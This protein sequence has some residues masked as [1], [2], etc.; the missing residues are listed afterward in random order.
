MRR[1][2][3]FSAEKLVGD[4]L[5]RVLD[6]AQRVLPKGDR[7]L[8]VGR[9]RA[10]ILKKVGPLATADPAKVMDQ[11]A[12]I[13]DPK[14]IVKQELE[15]L[16]TAHRGGPP[17]PVV[18]WR[19]TKDEWTPGKEDTEPIP[20]QSAAPPR[21]AEPSPGGPSLAGPSSGGRSPAGSRAG[22]PPPAGSRAGG[23][24]PA[25]SRAGGPPPAGQ[26]L[27]GPAEAGGD[28]PGGQSPSVAPAPAPPTVRALARSHP[29]ETAAVLLLGVGGLIIPFIWLAGG[30]VAAASRVWDA[31]DK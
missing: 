26:P 23:P 13:G 29:L 16:E 9:T 14:T 19:P 5:S 2:A 28:Q 17:K 10:A 11:L 1:S 31:R 6:A 15:R 4:Y 21:P 20:R 30:L 3:N 18:L 12:E 22:G 24:P 8:F 27:P 7:L 25:G